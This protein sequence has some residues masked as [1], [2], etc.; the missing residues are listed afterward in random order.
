[1]PYT[2]RVIF[3]GPCAYVPNIVEGGDPG[4]AK[5]WSV[6]L[7]DI[8]KGL[9][10]EDTADGVRVDRH[11]AVVQFPKAKFD[12][13]VLPDIDL[14][15]R[16]PDRE[17]QGLFLLDG[18][19]V[20][21]DIPG[22]KDL[23]V[24][25]QEIDLDMANQNA[26]L[27]LLNPENPEDLRRKSM[28]WMPDMSW[29]SEKL[30]WFGREDVGYFREEEEHFGFPE[31]G[32]IAGHVL[33]KHGSLGTHKIDKLSTDG[34]AVP[35]IWE[36]RP[37]GAEVGKGIRRQALAN[38]I[39][40][41]AS[42]LEKPVTITV[43]YS[44]TAQKTLTLK[45]DHCEGEVEIYI[46]NRELEEIFL[47]RRF[48]EFEPHPVDVDFRYLYTQAKGYAPESKEYH[49]PHRVEGGNGGNEVG[50]CGGTKFSGFA[51]KY[52]DIMNAW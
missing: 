38:S 39:A 19:R 47:P 17:P 41:E 11:R 6:I 40:L 34:Q 44:P 25:D 36:F 14:T 24:L 37:H 10:A 22:A 46:K 2:F 21:F 48:A 50:T 32:A 18:H 3:S 35:T 9:R 26:V 51:S 1:M 31:A 29:L 28:K 12:T 4:S 27:G 45:L 13:P 52:Q 23:E 30:Q 49:L 8:R 42:N 7:P 16:D 43:A 20:T 5:S 15:V 33:L